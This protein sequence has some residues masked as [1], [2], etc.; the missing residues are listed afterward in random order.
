MRLKPG[1]SAI[2]EDLAKALDAMQ[3]TNEAQAVRGIAGGERKAK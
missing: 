2:R 3:R 1:D